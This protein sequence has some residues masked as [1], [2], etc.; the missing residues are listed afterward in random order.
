MMPDNCPPWI[1]PGK[2]FRLI[3][4]CATYKANL[5]YGFI[6]IAEQ[7][8][9]FWVDLSSGYSL[10]KFAED[11][12]AVTI[13]GPSQQLV[14]WGVDPESRSEWR[15]T[16]DSHL[17]EMIDARLED[18]VMYLSVEVVAKEGY[19][20]APSSSSAHY[21]SA[22]SN[23]EQCLADSIGFNV[24]DTCSSPNT[25][26][27]IDW[28]ALTIIPEGDL[29]GDATILLDEDKFF[30]A[31]GLKAADEL[32]AGDAMGEVPIPAVPNEIQAEMIEAAMLVDDIDAAEPII[33]WDRDNPDISVGAVYPCMKDFRL[34]VK[35][36]AVRNEFELG[37]EKSDKVRFRG[38]CK[39]KGCPWKIR[40]RT[41]IDSSVRIQIIE[42]DHKCASRRL[43]G[44]MAS[45]GW[46]AERTVPLLKKNPGMGAA[47]VKA[48]LE[49]KYN[50][51]IPYQTVWYGKEKAAEK[52]FG[53]WDESYD[54]LYRFKAEVE[55]RSPGSVVEID[56][57]TV[58]GKK[59]FS[60]FFCA[61]KASIDGFLGGCRPYIS[62]DST[63][64][65]GQWNVHLPAATA[66]DGHN[67]MFPI[68]FGFFDSE[69][70]E[71]WIWFVQQLGKALG[72]MPRLA[73]CTDA[74]KGLET[75]VEKVFPWCEQRECFRHL[76]EDM[77]RNFTG[78]EYG[79]YMWPAARAY[80]VEKHK[81]LL[82]K[83]LEGTPGVE[84]W[85]ATHHK[86][87][88]ARS[89]FS[90]DI[91]CDYIKPS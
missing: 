52:L 65:N 83:V 47:E 11:M 86:L 85:L 31:M 55:L 56:T 80:T 61:F 2:A 42:G 75:A 81:R 89:K 41:Q 40:A 62:I 50:I 69:T 3:V 25:G 90:P 88:W 77:K 78:T 18:K 91:K 10:T 30:E 7:G 84:N 64:L 68:A 20:S 17:M 34:A 63:A 53:K 73:V 8:H 4:S 24:A 66:I 72:P 28:D 5:E 49:S 74:C 87:L 26:D 21:H 12:A 14:V 22:V 44:K 37:T 82:D 1:D 57:V 35:H 15:V 59:H 76:M 51:Q 71:N 6:D 46:V 9:D 13:W 70:K 45:Q 33:D 36:Y 43:L 58:D 48:E 27:I 54:Y 39:A 16:S 19:K 60:R 38:F 67:W 23:G 79:K 32:A 29:D